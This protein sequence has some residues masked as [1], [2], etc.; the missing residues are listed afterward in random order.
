MRLNY[1]TVHLCSRTAACVCTLPVVTAVHVQLKLL[2]L[3][4][5]QVTASVAPL[6][7]H[8][9]LP[10]LAVAV[11]IT[12]TAGSR[13]PVPQ[14]VPPMGH[15]CQWHCSGCVPGRGPGL[16]WQPMHA[17]CVAAT[18]CDT[19]TLWHPHCAC[20]CTAGSVLCTYYVTLLVHTHTHACTAL[21]AR[22][23][24]CT[25]CG[26]LAHTQAVA[27]TPMY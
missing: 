6:A 9:A 17:T 14:Q 23:R 15:P 24:T 22:T 3:P 18:P 2:L 4:P 7:C 5:S 20:A 10:P 26:S 19:H 11:A 13:W 16:T 1:C 27:S 25:H 8:G 12:D 21:H